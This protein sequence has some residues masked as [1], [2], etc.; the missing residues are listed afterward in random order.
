MG[1][2]AQRG[3]IR[4]SGV[5]YN[6]GDRIP[7]D[8][9]A[10][11]GRLIRLGYVVRTYD[12]QPSADKASGDGGSDGF[13]P[14]AHTID[15]VLSHLDDHPDEAGTVLAAERTGKD[16]T[17]LVAELESRVADDGSDDDEGGGDGGGDG[18]GE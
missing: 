18:G 17:T 5:H 4:I 16:R 10:T 8:Q 13:D 9:G 12:D 7:D 11:L 1:Y 15:E 6:A 14:S 2:I 3:G